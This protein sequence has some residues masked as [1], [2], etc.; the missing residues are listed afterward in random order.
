MMG[1]RILPGGRWKGKWQRIGEREVM[2]PRKLPG[3]GWKEMG[4]DERGR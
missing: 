4:E 3:G 1:P 2:G